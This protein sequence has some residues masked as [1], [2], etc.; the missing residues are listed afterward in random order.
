MLSENN[1]I[2]PPLLLFVR[3]VAENLIYPEFFGGGGGRVGEDQVGWAAVEH[4]RRQKDAGQFTF[5][6]VSGFT[7]AQRRRQKQPVHTALRP[8]RRPTPTAFQLVV[9][10]LSSH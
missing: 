9:T 7:R 3:E 1:L 6:P 2:S 8:T 4:I 10:T 5:I